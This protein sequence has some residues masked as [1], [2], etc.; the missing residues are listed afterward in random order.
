MYLDSEIACMFILHDCL[1]IKVC[2]DKF[3]QDSDSMGNM[4]DY[5][6]YKNFTSDSIG[7]MYNYED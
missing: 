5:E 6:D 1:K 7:N 3:F 2:I 4:Y